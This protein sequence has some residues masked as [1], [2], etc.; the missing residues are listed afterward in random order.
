M[1]VVSFV[2]VVWEALFVVGVVVWRSALC[3][4]W[5]EEEQK[6]NEKKTKERS[7]KFFGGTKNLSKMIKIRVLFLCNK[8]QQKHKKREESKQ[9]NKQK[10]CKKDRRNNNT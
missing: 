3:F 1:F 6:K 7:Q 2:V 5:N 4:F 10:N 8:T 9:T